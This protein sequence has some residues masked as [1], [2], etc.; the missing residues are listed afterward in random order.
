MTELA[1]LFTKHTPPATC[2]GFGASGAREE[3]HSLLHAFRLEVSIAADLS[4]FVSEIPTSCTDQ[5]VDY[6][7]T[8]HGRLAPTQ[9]RGL[10]FQGHQLVPGMRWGFLC[11]L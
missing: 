10:Q 2:I 5:G 3:L 11:G 9:L 8:Q 6:R 1:A 4:Q 7:M